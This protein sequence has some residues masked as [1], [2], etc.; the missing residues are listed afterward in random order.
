LINR[1]FKASSDNLVLYWRG[2]GRVQPEVLVTFQKFDDYM[3]SRL[4]DI[5]K[6]SSSIVDMIKEVQ[7]IYREGDMIWYQFPRTEK[8]LVGLVGMLD[9]KA[10]SVS[11]WRFMDVPEPAQRAQTTLYFADHTS[12]NMCGRNAAQFFEDNPMKTTKWKFL[13]RQGIGL[14]VPHER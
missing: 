3:A 7:V 11:T 4:P 10:G 8:A 12:D 9:Y 6:S 5:Y 2:L 13:R 14:R 1:I